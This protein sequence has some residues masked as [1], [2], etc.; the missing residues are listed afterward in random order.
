MKL[1]EEITLEEVCGKSFKIRIVEA[2]DNGKA[3]LTHYLH[4]LKNGVSSYYKE[5]AI[6]QVK[7]TLEYK[8]P[9]E[10]IQ[11]ELAEEALQYL[12]FDYKENVLFPAPKKPQFTFIDRSRS[13][14]TRP[15][16]FISRNVLFGSFVTSVT[17]LQYKRKTRSSKTSYIQC[18]ALQ[19]LTNRRCKI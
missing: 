17:S 16:G 18:C 1:R 15:S 11:L 19:M 9:T 8:F 7:K 10:K 14:F 2:V 12:L 4:N 6:N 13:I 5:A 3:D